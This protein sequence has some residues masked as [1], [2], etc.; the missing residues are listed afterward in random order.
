[1]SEVNQPPQLLTLRA[2]P[3]EMTRWFDY[4]YLFIYMCIYVYSDS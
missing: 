3:T 2:A 1:M 4:Y